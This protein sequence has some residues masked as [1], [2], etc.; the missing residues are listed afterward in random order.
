M[1]C[2]DCHP[3][4]SGKGMLGAQSRSPFIAILFHRRQIVL[5]CF[6][7]RVAH[8]RAPL[9]V[10][11]SLFACSLLPIV[12]LEHV[13]AIQQGSRQF[14]TQRSGAASAGRPSGPAACSLCS[15]LL[16]LHSGCFAVRP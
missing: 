16:P 8:C 1:T 15:T 13:S 10:C 2:K 11:D 12:C 5:Q 14:A 9:F 6:Y 4:S 3:K 7:R